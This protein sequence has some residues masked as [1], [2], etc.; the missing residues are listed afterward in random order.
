MSPLIR[1]LGAWIAVTAFAL[2]FALP[3]ANSSHP[4]W[5]DDA[6]AAADVVGP[7]HPHQQ[8][9]GVH[10]PTPAGHCALCHWLRAV[11]SAAP[12][13]TAVNAAGLEPAD[14]GRGRLAPW[15][16][17]LVVVEGASRAPPA[18]AA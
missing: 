1:R 12:G 7:T 3:L 2:G 14:A 8:F 13:T 11:S 17:R 9:E 16:G 10:Q 4:I 15:H 18:I 6:C 5:D